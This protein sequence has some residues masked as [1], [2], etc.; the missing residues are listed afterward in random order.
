MKQ[1]TFYSPGT[2]DKAAL[3]LAVIACRTNGCWAF[4]E[5]DGC[6]Q[7]PAATRKKRET[8]E[9]TA[10]RAIREKLSQDLVPTATRAFSFKEN[11]R[12]YYGM[13]FFAEADTIT[14]QGDIRVF[15]FLPANLAYPTISA[16]LFSGVQMWLNLR[17]GANEIWDIYD[18]DRNPTGRLHRRGDF[19]TPGDYHI[20]VQAW[21]MNSKGEFLLTKRAP[22]KGNPNMWEPTSGSAVAGDDSKSAVL[23]EIREETGLIAD[24]AKGSCVISFRADTCFVD[25]WLFR[26]D[27]NLCDVVLQEGETCDKMYA[28]KHQIRELLENGQFVPCSYIDTLFEISN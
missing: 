23:R 27:F 22:N 25:V 6:R 12:I 21:L 11:G 24:P 1:V 28:S 18:K 9:D 8:I 7:F 13:L 16:E 17:C 26:Q 2:E 5:K 20:V 10:K 14:E 19:L 3:T 4:C 15:P